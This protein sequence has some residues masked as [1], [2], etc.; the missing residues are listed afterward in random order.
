MLTHDLIILGEALP[1]TQLQSVL[2]V[3]VLTRS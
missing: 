1:D 2:P 3:E